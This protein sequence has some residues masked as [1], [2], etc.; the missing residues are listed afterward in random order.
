M[1]C[2]VREDAGPVSRSYEV[3]IPQDRVDETTGGRI[4]LIFE[5]GE[6]ASMIERGADRHQVAWAL[7]ISRD[8]IPM[9]L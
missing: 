2:T 7:W 9:R 1:F 5:H 6:P 8:P 4:S 3:T